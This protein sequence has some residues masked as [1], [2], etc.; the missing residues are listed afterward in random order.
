[1]FLINKALL[2]I[3]YDFGLSLLFVI[4][5]FFYGKLINNYVNGKFYNLFYLVICKL[6]YI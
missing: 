2:I 6:D 5:A 4:L 1:M 3:Y